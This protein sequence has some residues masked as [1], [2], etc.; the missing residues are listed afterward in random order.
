MESDAKLDVV[1]QKIK[2]V[3]QELVGE[4]MYQF[5]RAISPGMYASFQIQS[6][7]NLRNLKC[8]LRH[9]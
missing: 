2:Q 4:D 6:R 8:N 3:A 7:C 9:D 5:H 1:R